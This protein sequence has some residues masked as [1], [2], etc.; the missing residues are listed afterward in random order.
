MPVETTPPPANS[1]SVPSSEVP[2]PDSSN[3]GSSSSQTIKREEAM[4]SFL[5]MEDN[6]TD[7]LINSD[8]VMLIKTEGS[9]VYN[10][11]DEDYPMYRTKF[12]MNTSNIYKNK[13]KISIEDVQIDQYGGETA[14]LIQ[15]A[16]ELVRLNVG[17]TYLFAGTPYSGEASDT[18]YIIK[19]GYQGIFKVED[20]VI[21]PF[22]PKNRIEEEV[23]GKTVEEVVMIL[24]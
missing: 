16:Y 7:L 10:S 14:T 4:V 18:T 21:V 8:L 2:L 6:I 5:G 1:S 9:S 12:D 3:P 24:S 23:L 22:N 15:T 17:D 19:G 20:G 13:F 11:G